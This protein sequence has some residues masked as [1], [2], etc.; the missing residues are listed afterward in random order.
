MS[1]RGLKRLTNK[2]LQCRPTNCEEKLCLQRKSFRGEH[3]FAAAQFE[4]LHDL[5][6]AAI[7]MQRRVPNP[8]PGVDVTFHANSQLFIIDKKKTCI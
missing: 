6:K 8:R 1:A 3:C 7:T 5:C 2:S 4:G